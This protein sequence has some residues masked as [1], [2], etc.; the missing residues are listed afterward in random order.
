MRRK[1]GQEAEKGTHKRRLFLE[2][3]EMTKE[4]GRPHPTLTQLMGMPSS[5]DPSQGVSDTT[6]ILNQWTR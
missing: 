3:H 4:K 1:Y 2:V 5:F 6:I